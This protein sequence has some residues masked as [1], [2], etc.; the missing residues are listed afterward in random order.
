MNDIQ[1]S[2]SKPDISVVIVVGDRRARAGRA[3]QSVLAQE[4]IDRA[5]VL[6]VDAAASGATPIPGQD[7]P[8]V[9]VLPGDGARTYGALKEIGLREAQGEFVAFLEEH[10]VMLPGYLN[11]LRAAFAGPWDAVGGVCYNVNPDEGWSMAM[12]AFAYSRWWPP[13]SVGEVDMIPGNN[14]AY[15]RERLLP[16]EGEME[17]LLSCDTLLQWRLL[18]SGGRLFLAPIGFGHP[19]ET[20]RPNASLGV[21]GYHRSFA[22]HRARIFGWSPPRR[23]FRALFSLPAAWLRWLRMLRAALR[24]DNALRQL[25][26][27]DWLRVL[28]LQHVAALALA[29]GMLF[30]LGRAEEQL[31][32]VEVNLDRP[33]FDSD[34]LPLEQRTAE[35]AHGPAVT[36]GAGGRW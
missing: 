18:Q 10:S 29:L 33:G 31:L 5:E 3:L 1:G 27:I 12:A 14:S 9:R 32:E 36:D 8:S 19:T 15:R 22:H 21:I 20:N 23:L 26:L 35:R 17:A 28:Y 16:F 4:G 25:G 34:Q 13:G 7:H 24:P 6:L 30:G 2:T 11:G